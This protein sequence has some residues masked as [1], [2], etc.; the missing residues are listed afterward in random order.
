MEKAGRPGFSG[1]SPGPLWCKGGEIWSLE[2]HLGKSFQ[3]HR[4]M[5]LGRSPLFG[6]SV[7]PDTNWDN[8]TFLGL[9]KVVLFGFCVCHCWGWPGAE[10]SSS[11][12]QEGLLCLGRE[13]TC[14]LYPSENPAELQ[15]QCER[16]RAGI[17]IPQG[18]YGFLSPLLFA[19]EGS[20]QVL[21]SPS[22]F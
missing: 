2:L 8:R 16:S 7:F 1:F 6:I 21:W 14:V 15:L 3:S 18:D 22:P 13:E 17:R 11:A 4:E 5:Q 20:S 9:G 10:V 19:A 12:D